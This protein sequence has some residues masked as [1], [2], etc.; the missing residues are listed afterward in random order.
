[1]LGG[2]VG[3]SFANLQNKK[4]LINIKDFFGFYLNSPKFQPIFLIARFLQ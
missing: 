3:G 2:G 1:M 4:W